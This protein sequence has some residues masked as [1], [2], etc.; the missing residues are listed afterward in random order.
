MD[1]VTNLGGRYPGEIDRVFWAS[2]GPKNFLQHGQSRYKN[3]IFQ[4]TNEEPDLETPSRYY[5][6]IDLT[7][8]N[9]VVLKIENL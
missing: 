3:F 7:G 5:E 1:R 8:Q 6:G 2:M 9:M 4:T